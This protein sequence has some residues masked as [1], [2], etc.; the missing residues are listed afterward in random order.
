MSVTATIPRRHVQLRDVS[1]DPPHNAVCLII[2]TSI[3][4]SSVKSQGFG[5]DS[6]FRVPTSKHSLSD[7]LQI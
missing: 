2:S 6:I 5:D 1:D 4:K 7:S 3:Y